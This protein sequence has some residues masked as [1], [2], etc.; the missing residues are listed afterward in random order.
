MDLQRINQHKQSFDDI[1]RHITSNDGK[2]RV[3]VW[4]ARELQELL[5]YA[6]GHQH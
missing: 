6:T 3:E 5:G 1:Q 2:E 4:F